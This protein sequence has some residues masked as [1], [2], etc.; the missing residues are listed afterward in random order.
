M[1]V[2]HITYVFFFG[3]T[4]FHTKRLH[5]W[6]VGM[7]GLVRPALGEAAQDDIDNIFFTLVEND[8]CQKL[9]DTN[10]VSQGR[11]CQ[12]RLERE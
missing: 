3:I 1:F 12:L 5:D 11:L 8:L 6:Y 9:E 7:M 10:A 4:R 2:V